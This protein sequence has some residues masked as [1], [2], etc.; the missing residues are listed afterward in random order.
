[1]SVRPTLDARRTAGDANGPGNA[2]AP[3]WFSGTD[4]STAPFSMAFTTAS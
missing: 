4:P 3:H 2:A 1:M